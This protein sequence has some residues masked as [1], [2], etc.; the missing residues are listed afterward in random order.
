M[1]CLIQAA[2]PGTPIIYAP[3]LAAMDP[4]T[5]LYSAGRIENGIMAVAAIEMGQ[6]YNLPVEGTGGGSDH[7]RPGIQAGYER[8]ISTLLPVI[9]QP[10]LLVGVGLLG[11][12]MILSLEQLIIDVETFRMSKHAAR[13][14]EG[15][16]ESWLDDVIA[17]V[18]P[19]GH[20]LK[21]PSTVKAIRGGEWYHPDLG[22]HG[23]YESWI[24]EDRP[25]LID[26]AHERVN[27]LLSEHKPLPFPK[28]VEAELIKIEKSAAEI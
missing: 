14:I 23:T 18:G 4:R 12:S 9:S 19:G 11:G 16:E 27:Q 28:E 3:A 13:G 15:L 17:K 25:N 24:R 20:Y 6:Y 10:D 22:L 26:Q 2:D 1:L 7:F 5:G 21:E 8:S